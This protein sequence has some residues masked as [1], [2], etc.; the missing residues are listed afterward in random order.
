[1]TEQLDLLDL[2]DGETRG[3]GGQDQRRFA[4]VMTCMRDA[5]PEAMRFMIDLWAP[6]DKTWGMSGGWSYRW[7]ATSVIA[8]SRRPGSEEQSITW[9]EFAA[10]VEHH[11]RRK[12]ILEWDRSLKAPDKWRDLTRPHEMWPYGFDA[13]PSTINSERQRPGWPER[14]T[15]W[16][17]LRVILT[18]ALAEAAPDRSEFRLPKWEP[19]RPV[20]CCRF[21]RTEI[22][23]G[24]YDSQINHSP[25]GNVCTAQWLTGNHARHAQMRL[26]TDNRE[27][28]QKCRDHQERRKPC[29]QE[30]FVKEYEQDV[31]RATEL[32]GGDGWKATS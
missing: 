1:M 23:V 15:A 27:Q 2:I 5:M 21:C 9:D 19:R 26:D 16:R 30:C 6:P 12:S 29:P 28:D 8:K 13:H 25:M 11:P 31:A 7:S 10:L 22:K 20:A 3:N 32:W 17:S 18:D 14:I 4:E 24:S